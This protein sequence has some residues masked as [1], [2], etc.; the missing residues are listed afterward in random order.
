M[1]LPRVGIL[2]ADLTHTHGWA[3]YSTS[4]IAALVRAG[5]EV[6]V[7]MAR[8]SP[9]MDGIDVL[10]ILPTVEPLERRLSL[11]LIPMLPRA[12][13]FFRGC[14][15]IH[16][17]IEPYAPL[18][19][20][21]ASRR[22]YFIT[23]HGSYVQ[24]EQAYRWWSQ[25]VYWRA[26]RRGTMICVSH[27]TASVVK[28]VVPQMRTIVIPNGIDPSRFANLPDVPKDGRTVLSV[29]TIKPRK[30]TLQLVRAMKIVREAMPDVRCTIAGGL[31]A[32]R[33]YV[34]RVKSE[35]KKL[36]LT[37]T[38]TLLGRVG[39]D[40]LRTCF[41]LADVFALPSMND[42]WR[43]EGFGLALL[44]ASAAGLPVIGTRG[45]G[46]EDAVEDGVTGLLIP[47]QGVETA[48][49]EAI[50]TLL[51]DPDMRARMGSA[52]KAKAQTQTWD[53]A[54]A[55]VLALYEK[56]INSD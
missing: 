5:A 46:V 27:Y 43:F 3:H 1:T 28:K 54:A 19:A 56:E 47:Q 42:G 7:M 41:A 53:A 22:P 37:D 2:A 31:D 38:V 24:I 52:G 9:I 55:G 51:R 36:G 23:G 45:C 29:G 26:F 39:N 16:S 14:D 10:P 48:L 33:G 25:P 34:E 20:W 4:L 32:D 15:V 13:A 35:I 12:K 50:L 30:G 49:A 21:I 11:K 6:K 17:L 18:G 40:D 8:N 44:E